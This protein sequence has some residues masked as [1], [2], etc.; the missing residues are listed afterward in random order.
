MS[1]AE[2]ILEFLD[3]RKPLAYCDDCLSMETAVA[4]RQ[5]VYAI[6]TKLF[7]R[8]TISRA[9]GVCERCGRNKLVNAMR[10]P[11][12][13]H[14]TETPARIPSVDVEAMR[15][16]IVRMCQDLAQ[17]NGI[18]V[19]AGRGV[20]A[21]INRLKDEDVIPRHQANM[22]MTICNLRNVYVWDR[23]P[24]GERENVIASAALNIIE[25]WWN[26]VN[27]RT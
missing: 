6:C 19:P 23:V 4:P 7:E 22:M 20:A 5:Q 11:A 27:R 13:L 17:R 1:H 26:S 16:S 3:E 9:K 24:L 14:H 21:L 25:E 8:Q 15:T 18:E 12:E 10:A 2:T